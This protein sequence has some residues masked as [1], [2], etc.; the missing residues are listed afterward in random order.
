MNAMNNFTLDLTSGRLDD[1]IAELKTVKPK[2]PTAEE[3]AAIRKLVK[4]HFG[5]QLPK[6]EDLFDSLI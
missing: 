1:L 3:L 4:E 2:L 5:I 6:L